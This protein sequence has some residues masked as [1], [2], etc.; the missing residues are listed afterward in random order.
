MLPSADRLEEVTG[1]RPEIRPVRVDE[2]GRIFEMSGE[3]LEV[4]GLSPED[5][6]EGIADVKAGRVR[7]LKEIVASWNSNGL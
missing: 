6:L 1:L 5:V 7:P 2:K 4:P 3:Q